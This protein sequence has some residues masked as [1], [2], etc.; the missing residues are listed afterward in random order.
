MLSRRHRE[1]L[2]HVYY[3]YEEKPDGGRKWHM[4]QRPL[5][6]H[7]VKAGL[8]HW[9]DPRFNVILWAENYASYPFLQPMPEPHP[10]TGLAERIER[11]IRRL[12]NSW[13]FRRL[14]LEAANAVYQASFFLHFAS[15]I[16]DMRINRNHAT[17]WWDV[18][19]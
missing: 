18:L 1:I 4:E 11:K 10:A 13:S 5:S 8:A 3:A 14:N 17:S 15:K 7:V 6:Y 2:E 16:E 12:V 9:L 19:A